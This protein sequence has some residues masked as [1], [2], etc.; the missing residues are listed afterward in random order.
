MFSVD[1][2]AAPSLEA[3]QSREYSKCDGANDEVPVCCVNEES[4]FFV[5]HEHPDDK[6]D[7]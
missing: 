7:K 3:M 4:D 5:G 6:S 1:V 2:L